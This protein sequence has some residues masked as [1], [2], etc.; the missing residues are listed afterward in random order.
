MS[1]QLRFM[2]EKDLEQVNE[3]S[4]AAFA[5]LEKKEH[6]YN[7]GARLRV[8]DNW[9][10]YLTGNENGNFV[11]EDNDKIVGYCFTHQWGTTGFIGP[12]G[13][14][15]EY[16]GHQIGTDLLLI[17]VDSL[18]KRSVTTL[19]L[20]GIPQSSS[21]IAFYLKA[22]FQPGKLTCSLIRTIQQKLPDTLFHETLE[23]IDYRK[24]SESERS[25]LSEESLKITNAISPGLDFLFEMERTAFFHFGTTLFFI[26]K[27]AVQGFA[28]LHDHP[29][30]QGEKKSVVR[31]KAM[32]FK[33]G[34]SES[35]VDT[36]FTL[37]DKFTRD[38]GCE[39]FQIGVN[40]HHWMW[41]N[42]LLLMGFLI[43]MTN[44]RMLYPGY[45]ENVPE[46]SPCFTR[47]VG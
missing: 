10:M 31:V 7:L 15:P 24:V 22:G 23:C 13:V 3:T 45:Q 20:E 6:L 11:A 17:G 12:L 32:V 27:S 25:S 18:I 8:I 2:E 47:W 1:I 21:N 14:E 33:P 16:Q 40:C 4:K 34:T 19:G 29:Y 35:V 37:I 26:D 39:I 28:I 9:R 46:E 42:H 44:V 38:C 43:E 5:A 30:F 36:A 41:L